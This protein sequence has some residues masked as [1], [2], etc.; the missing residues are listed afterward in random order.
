MYSAAPASMPAARSAL[1]CT[2]AAL[3]H[4]ALPGGYWPDVAMP[5]GG[6]DPDVLASLLRLTGG[7]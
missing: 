3:S 1:A 7:R 4:V 2:A 6:P 5:G